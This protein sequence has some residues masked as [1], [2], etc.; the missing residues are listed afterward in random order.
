M[1][2]SLILGSIIIFVTFLN[3]DIKMDYEKASDLYRQ[4]KYAEALDIFKFIADENN[5]KASVRV[6]IMYATGKGTAR[7]LGKAKEWFMRASKDETG[8]AD[9]M[10]GMFYSGYF[11]GADKDLEESIKWVKKSSEKGNEEALL[12]LAVSYHKGR[13]VARDYGEAARLY[14]LL[15]EKNKNEAQYNLCTLYNEGLGVKQDY[16]EAIKWCSK[17]AE[18]GHL[19]AKVQMGI[20][21]LLGQG[22][23]KDYTKALE[24]YQQAAKKNSAWAIRNIGNLYFSGL[25][26]EKSYIKAREY[27]Q[28]ACEIDK[29]FGCS[30]KEKLEN[31]PIAQY[32]IAYAYYKGEDG[33]AQDYS[34]AFKWFEKSA[35]LGD[36]DAQN[37]LG[38]MYQY[39]DGVDKN[40]SKAVEWFQKAA[41]NGNAYGQKNL[42]DLY[43]DGEGVTQNFYKA[44][45]LYEKS[46]A[47]GNSWSQFRLAY[48]Y[49]N[50]E[51][52]LQDQKKAIEY[53]EKAADQGEQWA[54]NDLGVYYHYTQLGIDSLPL[55]YAF[56]NIAA[57]KGN[58]TAIDNRDKVL[59]EMTQKQLEIGQDL[60]RKMLANGVI[61]TRNEYFSSENIRLAA[62]RKNNQQKSSTNTKP[63]KPVSP[64]PPK[65]AKRPGVTSC[66][67]NCNNG[68]C[69]RT[70]DN[71]KQKHFQISPTYN[72]MS[73]QWEY[74]SGPC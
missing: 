47:Q 26:V 32:Y 12:I 35:K 28:Q 6:G 56:Y 11:N 52:I 48:M 39:G 59:K 51:G 36:K 41:D 40:P 66:N 45:E 31:D 18:Q 68:D 3:A 37:R 49:M 64:Y 20:Y 2:L 19:D 4:E 10:I 22:V 72:P 42:A 29:D 7:D 50:G 38:L 5:T 43:Y 74:N 30:N 27:Y 65:P 13:G 25:G 33:L 21:Y 69:Y 60:S 9:L 62:Q 1:R 70:Y 16:K 54:W 55:A 46:A 53:Y 58:N 34:E 8:L 67:T 24:W 73:S 71:G 63:A 44:S 15:A 14:K 61:K 23:S 17:A 57:S